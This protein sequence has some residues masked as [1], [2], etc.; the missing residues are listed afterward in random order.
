MNLMQYMPHGLLAACLF[1]LGQLL[2]A[3]CTNSHEERYAELDKAVNERNI[4][5]QKKEEGIDNLRQQLTPDIS[6]EAKYHICNRIFEEYLAYKSD[7]AHKYVSILLDIA[8]A[9]QKAEYINDAEINR[10]FLLSTSGVFDK[11][12]AILK[13]LDKKSFTNA[14]YR[15]Y[16]ESYRWLY[17]TWN[18]YLRVEENLPEYQD[19]VLAYSDSMLAVVPPTDVEYH[20]WLGEHYWNRQEYAEAEKEYTEGIRKISPLSRRY[21]SITCSMAFVCHE[22][23]KWDEFEKYMILSAIA[24]QKIPLKENLAMQEIASYLTR[25]NDIT[26]ANRYLLCSLEDAI[27]YN[28]RLRLTQIARKFPE[29]VVRYQ[30]HEKNVKH[31]Q[32]LVIVVVCLLA[33]LMFVFA[34]FIWR[35]NKLLKAQRKIRIQLNKD[36]NQLNEELQGANLRLKHTNQ[37]REQYVSLF[38]ELCAAYIDKYNKLL[39]QVERKVKLHQEDD[40]L[41][42]LHQNRLKDTDTKEFFLNFDKAFLT[43]YPTFIEEFNQ[44]LYPDKQIT[45]K[46]GEHLSNELR[47]MALIRLGVKD[48]QK[49]STLL[50]YSPQTIYNYRSSMKNRAIDKENFEKNVES[51]SDILLT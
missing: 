20:Y 38:I 14:N 40:I 7:S 24:D 35:H 28:N 18:A 32:T 30:I 37:I 26:R 43:L 8:R 12:E 29:V 3:S 27:F 33:V 6:L 17:I 5:I 25:K 39:K 42:V 36:L 50:L 21:A 15:H 11:A 22:Q 1:F 49:I 46:K 16:Y 23:G 51:I 41:S 10:S 19:K 34:Y 13:R 44:L 4:Y 45:L 2:C 9:I 48:T 47:L 31:M